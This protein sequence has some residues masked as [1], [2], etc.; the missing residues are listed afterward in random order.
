MNFNVCPDCRHRIDLH[1]ESG[2]RVHRCYCMNAHDELP[3]LWRIEKLRD[4]LGDVMAVY[5]PW[6]S[7]EDTEMKSALERCYEIARRGLSNDK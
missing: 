5:L 3:L 6:S 7:H 4:A 1:D 2:C